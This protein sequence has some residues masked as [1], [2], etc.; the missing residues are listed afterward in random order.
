VCLLDLPVAVV[1]QQRVASVQDAGTPV[2]DRR[3]ML[4]ERVAASAGLDAEQRH[5]PVGDEG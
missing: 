5:L 3:G 4:A 2:R 1:E